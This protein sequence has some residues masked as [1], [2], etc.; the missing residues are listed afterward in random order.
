MLAGHSR[1]FF[2]NNISTEEFFLSNKEAGGLGG[3]APQKF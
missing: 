2:I 1:L 3:A